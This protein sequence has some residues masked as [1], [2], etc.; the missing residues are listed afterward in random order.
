MI[1]K[2]RLS[3]SSV[4]PGP[5]A[6]WVFA[7]YWYVDDTTDSVVEV[8]NH[9]EIPL[10]LSP[11]VRL[12]TGE[13][14]ELVPLTLRPFETVRLS[15]RA[16]LSGLLVPTPGPFQG[17]DRWG[18]GSRAHSLLGNM[19]LLPLYPDRASAADFSAWIVVEGTVE[20]IALVYPFKTSGSS[21]EVL[22]GIWWRPYE[23]TSVYYALQNTSDRPL[24]VRLDVFRSDGVSIAAEDLEVEP[25]GFQLLDLTE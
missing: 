18:N 5:A 8:K 24:G 3:E 7:Q 25:L 20:G 10:I 13:L 15:L 17:P 14:L 11:R 22:E 19:Y 16:Q 9:L 6:Q 2:N 1:E 12:S 21:S 4:S 23:A